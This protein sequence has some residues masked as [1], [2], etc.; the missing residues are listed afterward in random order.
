MLSLLLYC[1]DHLNV[2]NKIQA[3]FLA[4]VSVDP[5]LSTLS[6][7]FSPKQGVGV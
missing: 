5:L 6:K 7:L 4:F 3:L 2:F 1:K